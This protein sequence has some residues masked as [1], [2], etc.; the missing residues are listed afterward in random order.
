MQ[1]NTDTLK[2][3]E[4][5]FFVSLDRFKA[6]V[7]VPRLCH[8]NTL[9]RIESGEENI[10]ACDGL[11]TANQNSSLGVATADCAPICFGD[12]EKIGIAHIGWRGLC[13]GLIEKMLP[14]FNIE[15]LE[16]FV[17]P[18]LYKFEIQK[19][20]CYEMITK[21]FGENFFAYEGDKVIFHFRDAIASCLPNSSVFDER[22]TEEDM[23]LPSHRRNRMPERLLTVVQFKK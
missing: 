1:R 17:G 16:V 11:I 9:I 6:G 4:I 15:A 18:H 23:A 14:E 21:K 10:D 12:G 20:Y 5:N 8:G 7:I 19:D 2:E 13:L 3:M 22:N